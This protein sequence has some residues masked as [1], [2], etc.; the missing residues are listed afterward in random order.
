MYRS[1][2]IILL[3]L[4]LSYQVKAQNNLTDNNPVLRHTMTPEEFAR[5]HEIG[6]NFIETPP[7]DGP[8]RNV[9]EYDRMQGALIRYPFGIP[10][11]LIKE[12]A[13]NVMVTTIVASQTQKTTV[14]NQYVTNGVD[15]SHCNFLIA[16][17]DSYWTRDYGPWFA[18]D[19]SK[20]IGIVDFPY[21]RPRPN[22]DE[23]PKLFAAMLGI[24][25]Y[26][27]NVISTGGNYM[28]DGL[29]ISSST[30]LVYVENPT[31]TSQQVNN[32]MFDYLGIEN[33]R[34]VPDPNISSTIDHIDCW[35]KFLGPDKI[36]IRQV[37]PTDP[38]YNALENQATYWASQ[39][40]SYG[41]NYRVFRVKTPQDQPYTNSVILNNKVL[42]PFMNSAW[43]D[44]AK[45]AYEAAMPGYTV[46]GFIASGSSGWLST[47]ALHCRV[48]GVADV[49]L[50]YI[51]HIPLSGVKPC[52]SDY[53]VSATILASSQM[54]VIE[55]SVRIHYRVNGGP[56]QVVQMTDQSSSDYSGFIPK[57]PAGSLV[58][59]YLSAADES[60]RSETMPLIGA[61]DPF[62]FTTTYTNLT[63][64]PDTLW[65]ITPDDCLNG[66][67]TQLHN[68][69]ITRITLDT[70]Q[71]YGNSVPWMVDSVSV[72][73]YPSLIDPGDS[74]AVRVRVPVVVTLLPGMNFYKD[75]LEY[76]TSAG[77]NYVIIMINSDLLSKIN[78]EQALPEIGRP[79]PNPFRDRISIPLSLRQQE[80]IRI[81]I[82]DLQGRSITVLW[83]GIADAGDRFFTWDGTDDTGNPAGSG[84]YL[85]KFTTRGRSECQKILLLR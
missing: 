17:T 41:Y 25:W 74:V 16:P 43:D 64:V 62:Q 30:D 32:K 5:R 70:I 1:I 6:R 54:P 49:G 28:T 48:M 65:F 2:S 61:A 56:Y 27:M 78:E 75:S 83:D 29:G 13:T 68:Y 19:S 3:I 66:K 71:Q 22:D 76:I 45:A 12:M 26:G 23:I 24:P 10:I 39:I 11:S 21:N 55:D 42:V 40:C 80:Q 72:A 35:G 36:L 7:P 14:L 44:S 50:L 58:E 33:F 46:K 8:V 63:P 37:L 15:T 47:D 31:Q 38:E 82:L 60:G 9:A 53:Q 59:Y 73:G 34:V 18:T 4:A 85:L 20:Q 77:S 57:Q 79:Y 51:R 67:I 84:I 69:L 52:E 81:E